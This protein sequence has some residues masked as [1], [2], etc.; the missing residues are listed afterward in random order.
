MTQQNQS[1][2]GEQWLSRRQFLQT[3]AA[4]SAA[5]LAG[6][7][8]ATGQRTGPAGLAGAPRLQKIRVG[9]IGCGGRGTDAAKDCM[10]ADPNV[11]IVALGDVFPDQLDS[12]RKSLYESGPQ[13]QLAEERCFSGFDAYKGVLNSGVD[14]VILATP[15]GFRPLHLRAAVEAGKHVFMEKPVAVDPAGV[16]SV[17]A[18]GD[19]ATQNGLSIVTGTQRRHQARYLEVMKRVQHGEIGEVVG[20][21]CYWNQEGLWQDRV[22]ENWEKYQA[23]KCCDMEWQIRNWLFICWLSGD[24]IVEQH[25]HNID[26]MN[27]AMG[28]PPAKAVGEGGRQ[29]RVAP[30][31]GNIYDHFAVEYEYPNGVRIASM[32]RQIDKA[33]TRVTERLVGT[34]GIAI[35]G[36][37]K[38]LR[39][40]KVVY[41]FTAEETNPYLQEHIDLIASIRNHKPVNEAR[42]IAEST[43]TAVMGRMSAYTGRELSWD[44]AMNSSKLD[45]CPAEYKMGECP[46]CPVPV[47]GA[48]ELI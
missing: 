14:L 16:R 20:G 15:P 27:W 41:E 3:S 30:E 8:A 29:S 10:K 43:M 26:V 38:I 32:C 1:R 18:S 36:E 45:L 35:P 44:W 12:S 31:Y 6:G 48:V 33:S 2:A 23:K 46:L 34:R 37:G 22:K 11:E 24:H 7:C 25:V 39:G 13:V 4:L 19:L 40:S 5:A 17:I 28:G 42:R 9:V 47:P 21:Q